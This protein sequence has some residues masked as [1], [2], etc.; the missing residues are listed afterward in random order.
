M[1]MFPGR[2]RQKAVRRTNAS[3]LRIVSTY[4]WL[5]AAENTE[6]FGR[7]CRHAIDSLQNGLVLVY[8]NFGARVVS[9]RRKHDH[10]ADVLR[11]LNW[12]DARGLVT[13]HRL[14]LTHA[15]ITTGS[16]ECIAMCIG[17]SR[18][19]VYQTRGSSQRTLPRIHSESGRR[20]LSYGAVQQYNQLPFDTN[21]RHFKSTLRRY[22]LRELYG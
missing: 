8:A 4:G 5:S 3:K 19:H 18:D 11:D 21:T 22:L 16:P 10:V 20:R 14:C 6:Q 12:L 13:Y 17:P 2:P 9:G 15:A 7:P 1:S